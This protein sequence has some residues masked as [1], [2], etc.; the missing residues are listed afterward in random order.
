MRF[1]FFILKTFKL[2]AP[3]IYHLPPNL[4]EIVFYVV[5]IDFITHSI[6]Y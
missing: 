1:Y 6:S 4:L 3:I 2:I 5:I